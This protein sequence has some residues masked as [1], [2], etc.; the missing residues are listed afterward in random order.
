M[1]LH[2]SI[3]VVVVVAG[4]VVVVEYNNIKIIIYANFY[5]CQLYFLVYL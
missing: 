1:K 3:F 5:L 4:V 2:L